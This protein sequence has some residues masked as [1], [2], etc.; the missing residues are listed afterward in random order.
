MKTERWELESGKKLGGES[1]DLRQRRKGPNPKKKG[2]QR[3]EEKPKIWIKRMRKRRKKEPQIKINIW[4][5]SQR[6]IFEGKL[7]NGNEE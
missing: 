1:E 4:F 7:R 6:E 2:D 3:C 5:K